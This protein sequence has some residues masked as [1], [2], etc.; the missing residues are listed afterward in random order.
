MAEL[1]YQTHNRRGSESDEEDGVRSPGPSQFLAPTGLPPLPLNLVP[2]DQ[3]AIAGPGL[4]QPLLDTSRA[5]CEEACNGLPRDA[6]SQ[7]PSKAGV[8]K[9]SPPESSRVP[10]LRPQAQRGSCYTVIDST[11]TASTTEM[12]ETKDE[13]G[14][15]ELMQRYY[16]EY[17]FNKIVAWGD[18][19]AFLKRVLARD[20]LHH[21]ALAHLGMLYSQKGQ[22]VAAIDTCFR[23]I[24]EP[25]NIKYPTDYWNAY[26]KSCLQLKR[27]EE[28]FDK[29]TS[30]IAEERWNEEAR[31]GLLQAFSKA[32]YQY[33]HAAGLCLP[34][35]EAKHAKLL[36]NPHHQAVVEATVQG[37]QDSVLFQHFDGVRRLVEDSQAALETFM[38]PEREARKRITEVL[39]AP[40]LKEETGVSDIGTESKEPATLMIPVE[41]EKPK[42]AKP[43]KPELSIHAQ[44][45]KSL[46]QADFKSGIPLSSPHSVLCW[47]LD[48]VIRWEV[49]Q[50]LQDPEQ[51]TLDLEHRVLESATQRRML[52]TWAHAN[53]LTVRTLYSATERQFRCIYEDCGCWVDGSMVDIPHL[54][55]VWGDPRSDGTEWT[56]NMTCPFCKRRQDEAPRS[57]VWYVDK[58]N[59]DMELVNWRGHPEFYKPRPNV[60]LRKPGAP[61]PLP[62]AYSRE[63][64]FRRFVG[65][66]SWKKVTRNSPKAELPLHVLKRLVE[67]SK[68]L[69]RTQQQGPKK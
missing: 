52:Y 31:C 19:V 50:F 44:R 54:M 23:F 16:N 37:L 15:E 41:A 64:C 1:A 34:D 45:L 42:S 57:I 14:P 62:V 22:H 49:L 43:A 38:A 63:S 67:Q 8:T 2:Q 6:E 18:K 55:E 9:L 35:L 25:V 36:L 11:Q 60:L 4:D 51:M 33:K 20:P 56:Y 17:K 65:Q 59:K 68:F 5:V 40:I 53:D 30:C 47:R 66:D 21:E 12:K 28:A 39:D 29:F 10:M 61:G 26:G 48:P 69:S 46:I 13:A 7:C 58:T 3:E 32:F 24:G 27:Y